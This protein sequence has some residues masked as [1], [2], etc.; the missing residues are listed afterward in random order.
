MKLA[1]KHIQNVPGQSEAVDLHFWS[2]S[3][4]A[5][6]LYKNEKRDL[7]G[8][9]EAILSEVMHGLTDRSTGGL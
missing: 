6:H 8:R 3:P 4:D 2:M 7:D 9:R 1:V 5:M